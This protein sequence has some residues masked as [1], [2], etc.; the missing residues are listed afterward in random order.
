MG[1]NFQVDG[2]MELDA[3]CGVDLDVPAP[4]LNFNYSASP[5]KVHGGMKVKAPSMCIEL[6]V[7][8]GCVDLKV[9]APSFGM[10][11]EVEAP[12]VDISLDMDAKVKAPCVELE[13]KLKCPEI[14]VK[15]PSFGFEV[16][17]PCVEL[18]IK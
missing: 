4:S 8:L 7:D 18:D 16:K 11:V 3:H 13:I 10:G 12:C 2:H 14:K 15:G 17:A 5:G 1:A 9:K 6:E